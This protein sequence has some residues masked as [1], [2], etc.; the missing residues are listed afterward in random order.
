MEKRTDIGFKALE[1]IASAWQVDGERT[2]W[3]RD[4][5]EW[6]PGQFRMS[7]RVSES[8]VY[9]GVPGYKLTAQTDLVKN[10]GAD[11][12]ALLAHVQTFGRL[13]PTYA[14][15]V[16][17]SREAGAAEGAVDLSLA[18]S[19]YLNEENSGWLPRF[20]S[21]VAI[22]QPVDAQTFAKPIAEALDGELDT[23]TPL[24]GEGH[25][26]L[27]EMLEIVDKIYLPLGQEISK[28]HGT[29]EFE[30]AMDYFSQSD[31]LFGNADPTGLTVETP[32][33][34]D[35]ALIQLVTG[36][37]HPRL[38]N[39][40]LATLQIPWFPGLDETLKAAETFNLMESETPNFVPQLG[41]WCANET[42]GGAVGPA[43]STFLPNAVYGPGLAM[44]L[45]GWMVARARWMKEAAWPEL[46]DST[47]E[48]ILEA[49]LAAMSRETG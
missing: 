25:L 28:W 1:G 45:A 39:G 9:A 47:M 26:P 11:R 32:F 13:A 21:S 18:T 17:P 2:N 44:Y 12:Q 35:S 14:A 36:Q 19:V 48:Q 42:R 33:G 16:R 23:S 30:Q 20:F 43:F 38:G 8:L 29:D 24:P 6:W 31:R 3:H 34:G 15:L 37:A 7:L 49:R 46:E 27:D 40:L 5:F 41:H 22:L 4:G 10:A